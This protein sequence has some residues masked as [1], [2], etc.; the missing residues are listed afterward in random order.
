MLNLSI[1]GQRA[2]LIELARRR[3]GADTRGEVEDALEHAGSRLARLL[4]ENGWCRSTGKSPVSCLH[5]TMTPATALAALHLALHLEVGTPELQKGL[6]DRCVTLGRILA[7]LGWQPGNAEP[8]KGKGRRKRY[9][10]P[11]R[12]TWTVQERQGAWIPRADLSG[13]AELAGAIDAIGR[14]APG[15]QTGCAEFVRRLRIIGHVDDWPCW[16]EPA[17]D[18]LARVGQLKG[19]H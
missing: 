15:A 17:A 7:P 16:F 2:S 12:T 9:Q 5:A 1:Q 3:R 6:R 10:P 4:N 14:A 13:S 19:A 11:A 8:S 18:A